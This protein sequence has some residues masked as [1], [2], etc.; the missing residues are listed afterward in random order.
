[1]WQRER[2]VTCVSWAAAAGSILATHI[3]LI[4]KERRWAGLGS[5]AGS[6]FKPCVFSSMRNN[7]RRCVCVVHGVVMQ[8][9]LARNRKKNE[10]SNLQLREKKIKEDRTAQ[11]N[12]QLKND[13]NIFARICTFSNV[14]MIKSCESCWNKNPR[15]LGCPGDVWKVSPG[16]AAM[17]NWLLCIKRPSDGN[18]V[19]SPN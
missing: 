19:V 3:C 17:R 7:V 14:W 16:I 11:V 4:K 12:R 8:R 15:L 9:P 2:A 6:N 1:M 5:P 13:P 18:F 10:Q